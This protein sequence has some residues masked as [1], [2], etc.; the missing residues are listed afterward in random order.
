M[1]HSTCYELTDLGSGVVAVTEGAVHMYL[2][3]GE[4]RAVLLDTGFGGGDLAGLIQELCEKPLLVVNSHGH[5]DH[6]GANTQFEQICAHPADWQMIQGHTG[7]ALERF[8]PLREGDRVD[9]GGR[10]LEVLEL[11]GHTPG[12]IALLDRRNRIIFIGDCVSDRTVFLCLEGASLPDYAGSLERLVGMAELFDAAYGGH[13]QL[14]QGMDQAKRLIACTQAV[15]EGK[16]I[17]V[18]TV[19]FSGDTYSK[20]ELDGAS[21][22]TV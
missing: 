4:E 7:E 1:G 16:L 6:T 22:Y 11:P 15:M 3:Q 19:V 21:I 10:C 17:G 14:C 9:L 2:I 5:V 12:S 18:P 20:Y 8:Q 13:G